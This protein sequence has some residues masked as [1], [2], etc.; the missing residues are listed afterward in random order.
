MAANAGDDGL[1]ALYFRVE[2]KRN[3]PPYADSAARC[4]DEWGDRPSYRARV[5]AWPGRRFGAGLITPLV[6]DQGAASR[7]DV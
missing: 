3:T 2:V 5:I 7:T 4:F 6:A 1:A